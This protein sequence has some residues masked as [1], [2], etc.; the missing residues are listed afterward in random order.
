MAI[1][2]AVVHQNYAQIPNETLQDQSLSFEARGLLSMLL[3]MPHD[4]AINKEWLISQSDAGRDK[5]TQ[6]KES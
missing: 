4:W 1:Y 5:F 6:A 2:K 3:S